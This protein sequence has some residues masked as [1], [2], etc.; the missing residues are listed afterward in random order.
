MAKSGKGIAALL[1]G[2]AIGAGVGLLFAPEKGEVTRGKIRRTLTARRDELLDKIAALSGQLNIP[3][4]PSGIL[5]PEFD[6]AD[7]EQLSHEMVDKLEEKFKEL[8]D[9]AGKLGK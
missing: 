2:V 3:F 8:K 1:L 7:R 5:E 4:S 6:A 9:A